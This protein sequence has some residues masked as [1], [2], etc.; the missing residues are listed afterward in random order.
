MIASVITTGLFAVS[1]AFAGRSARVLGGERANLYRLIIAVALLAAYAMTFGQGHEGPAFFVFF[2]SGVIGLGLGDLA[3]F[4]SL[5]RIGARLTVL[6]V[7]CMAAPIGAVLDYMLLSVTVSLAELAASA[8]ILSGVAFALYPEKKATGT[9][10]TT[11]S[12]LYWLAVGTALIGAFGQAAGAILSRVGYRISDE[13]GFVIDGP[14]AAYQRML[15]GLFTAALYMSVRLWFMKPLHKEL[16]HYSWYLT[17]INA[18][19]G[20][21]LGVAAYQIAL[22][23]APGVV[24][25]SIVATTPVVVIPLTRILEKDRPSVRSVAGAVIAVAGLMLMVLVG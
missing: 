1:A 21:V 25:L 22:M 4:Y 13:H 18:L 24:V 14:T 6:I 23:H 20:P 10:R 19:A 9:T 2:I 8:V 5:P 3:L 11:G 7:Q 16:I 12:F 15:G 17:L